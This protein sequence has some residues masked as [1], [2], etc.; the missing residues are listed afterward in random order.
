MA[1]ILDKFVIQLGL[2]GS[3]VSKGVLSTQ[4]SLR[5]INDD[6]DKT[7]GKLSDAGDR[8]AKAFKALRTEAMAAFALFT[9]GRSL[10]GFI[11]DTTEANTAL[12]NLSRQLDIAPQKLNQLRY[13]LQGAQAD[14]NA[15]ENMFRTLQAK[16]TDPREQARV[17][18]VAR[19]YAGVELYDRNN[20]VRSDLIEQLHGSKLFNGQSRAIQDW[21]LS[22]LGGQGTAN[23]LFSP[24]YNRLMKGTAGGGP[25][26]E[27]IRNAEKLKA[28]FAILAKSTN[29]IQQIIYGDL[30]PAVNWFVEGL[31][32]IEKAD[33][34]AAAH[35]VEVI[36][37]ALLLLS[38]ALTGAGILRALKTIKDL[39]NVLGLLRAGGALGEGATA[40]E[41]AASG[42]AAAAEGGG[43]LSTLG[44]GALGR[45]L[46]WLAALWP[47]QT[48]SNDTIDQS[49]TGSL[50]TLVGAVGMRESGGDATIV[51]PK[52]ATGLMQFMPRIAK[53]Y[54]IDPRDPV[55]SWHAAEK[56]LT[57][58]KAKYHGDQDKTL[59][60]YNWGEGNLDKD[61]AQLHGAWR[62]GLP[63]E[64]SDY[65]SAVNSN[66]RRGHILHL[67]DYQ[68]TP[69]TTVNVGGVH[70]H[71]NS[72]D[73]AKIGRDARNEIAKMGRR[74]T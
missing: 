38:G 49:K 48:A 72:T 56:M 10:E 41:G 45:A 26:D 1:N 7:G 40:A 35:G 39:K 12:G 24:Q 31:T 9:G 58:L 17:R 64:T 27:D 46:P 44:M 69:S 57:R 61:I 65:I 14:P 20:H 53:A 66:M 18:N 70:I 32:K 28:N 50:Q 51:S 25:S 23:L 13:A 60:A 11:K 47:N 54:G 22:E 73:G 62:Q 74:G 21:V 52:G 36:G 43:L 5:G 16:S 42:T 37:G 29:D 68:D 55:Q 19:N 71:T 63:H 3:E 59:A 2:D 4:R 67:S 34:K 8:G 30:S 6:V 33:P 15:A